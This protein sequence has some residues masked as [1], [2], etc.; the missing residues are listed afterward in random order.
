MQR[1]GRRL[2]FDTTN[3]VEFID[4]L[5]EVLGLAPLPGSN[6]IRNQSQRPDRVEKRLLQLQASRNAVT[7]TRNETHPTPVPPARR[8][9]MQFT[10]QQR[11]SIIQ[12]AQGKVVERLEWEPA[13]GGYWVLTFTD[14]VELCFVT[15]AEL[16]EP[17]P[18][19]LD[20]AGRP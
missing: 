15:M 14:G 7:F 4:A 8:P 10:A 19:P 11:A 5:R 13:D 9:T 18:L 1:G 17:R 2:H 12:E 16:T 20:A 3:V 6:C